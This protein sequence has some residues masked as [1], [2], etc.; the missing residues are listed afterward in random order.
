MMP[1]SLVALVIYYTVPT[2]I[3]SLVIYTILIILK[4]WTFDM[5]LM[6]V[7]SVGNEF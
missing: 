4:I 2:N 1:V 6:T 7:S 5:S 3:M